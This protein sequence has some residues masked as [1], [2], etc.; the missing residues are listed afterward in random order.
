MIPKVPLFRERHNPKSSF[1]KSKHPYMGLRGLVKIVDAFVVG[2]PY[3]K[4]YRELP[5]PHPEP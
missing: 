4:G 5:Y 3:K 2:V 1:P